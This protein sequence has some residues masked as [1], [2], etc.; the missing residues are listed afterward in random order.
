MCR[1]TKCSIRS[2]AL[3]GDGTFVATL[4]LLARAAMRQPLGPPDPVLCG[5]AAV[6]LY[7]GDL[8]SAGCIEVFA[9]DPRTLITE[10]F[11]AGFRWTG[12]PRLA[13]RGLWHPELQIGIDVI[14]HVQ[15][16]LAQPSNTL[17]VALD[18]GVTATCGSRACL[19]EGRRH[20]RSD[21]RG[22]SLHVAAGSAVGRGCGEGA[23]AGRARAGRGRRPIAF[24]LPSSSS[25]LG[26]A[27]RGRAR[28]LMA[29]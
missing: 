29:R 4:Q 27:R 6:R 9:A 22:S 20:R 16:G 3:P 5:A 19:A 15:R 18:L 28:G 12:R 21:R 25:G 2:I 11:A 8:W 23:R 26:D 13:D 17:T 10:L 1:L 24:R 7:T 14:D